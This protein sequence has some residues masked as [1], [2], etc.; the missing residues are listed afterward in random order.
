MN[1]VFSHDRE[2]WDDEFSGIIDRL[3][4]WYKKE[5][6]KSLIGKKCFVG[7]K[8]PAS[9][10]ELFGIDMIIWAINESA[11]DVMG[12]HAEDY[13]NLSREEK[14][15]F[16]DLIVGFLDKKDPRSFFRVVNIH[17]KTITEEDLEEQNGKQ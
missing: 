8:E 6:K 3:M 2:T 5:D 17:E 4:R 10:I 12:I 11:R 13:P 7:D 9:T 1:K 16:M 14:N 15:E